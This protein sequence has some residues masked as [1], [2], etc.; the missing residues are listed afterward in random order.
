VLEQTLVSETTERTQLQTAAIM[1]VATELPMDRL[2]SR[3]L[4]ESLGISEEWII[5]RTGIYERRRARPDERLTD[6]AIR[7][8]ARALRDAECGAAR[9]ACARR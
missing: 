4:A 3:E 9:R 2:T 1:S 8:G 6:Y 7:A 5:S